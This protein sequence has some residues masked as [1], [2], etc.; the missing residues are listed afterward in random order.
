MLYGNKSLRTK[1]II[2]IKNLY[3]EFITNYNK[4]NKDFNFDNPVQI[5]TMYNYLLNRGYLSK[6]K[7]YEFSSAQARDISQIAGTNVLTGRAVCR[8]T[9]ALLG[10][11]LKDYG[12]QTGGLVAYMRS[13]II[14][15]NT[16]SENLWT[17]EECVQWVRTHMV[18]ERAYKLL[19]IAIE[20]L[21]DEHNKGMVIEAK[22]EDIKNPLKRFFGN[23]AITFAFDGKYSYY[24]DPTNERI[25]R[26]V[27]DHTLM[28]AE[29]QLSIKKGSSILVNDGASYRF[30]LQKLKENHPSIPLEE[31]KKLLEETRTLCE[32]NMDVFDKF[33]AENEGLI[34]DISDR[35]LSLRKTGYFKFK[36]KDS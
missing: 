6:G 30:M 17:R 22:T 16:K 21:Y 11:I 24:L 33:Y 8:H 23:H 32:N 9:S 5:F 25:Y 35:V 4:L 13:Y 29:D 1:D 34:T 2:E 12:F 18:D 7:E 10:D 3:Q 28:D 31:E 14:N 26:A 36:R 20:V 27:D 19:M 15:I